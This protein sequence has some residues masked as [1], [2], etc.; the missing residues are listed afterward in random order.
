MGLGV[1]NE[2]AQIVHQVLHIKMAIACS[3]VLGKNDTTF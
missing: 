1:G 3:L 2:E